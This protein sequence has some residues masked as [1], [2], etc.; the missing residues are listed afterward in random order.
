MWRGFS[1]LTLWDRIVV[2]AGLML[3]VMLGV[4]PPIGQPR[5]VQVGDML[6]PMSAEVRKA[7]RNWDTA[8]AYSGAFAVSDSGR[9][10]GWSD[11]HNTLPAARANAIAH[12]AHFGAGCRVVDWCAAPAGKSGLAARVQAEVDAF[13]SQAGAGAFAISD[14]GASHW[15]AGQDTPE[16]AARAALQGC[17]TA[18]KKDQPAYLPD[19]P[20]RIYL[21]RDR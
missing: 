9:A 8:A 5:A 15:V 18:R 10:W 4:M 6:V 13:Q 7:Y 21:S 17:E 16:A 11:A 2:A 1:K 3:V 20:C 14:N 12:C 19:W